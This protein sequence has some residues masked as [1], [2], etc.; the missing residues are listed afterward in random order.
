MRASASD[1]VSNEH[2]SSASSTDHKSTIPNSGT[3]QH[4]ESQTCLNRFVTPSQISSAIAASER[5]R[6]FCSITFA[7]LV[8]LSYMGFPLLGSNIINSIISF[9]PLYLVL[10]TNLTLVVARL[11][12]NNRRGF[13]R[14]VAGEFSVPSTGKYDWAEQAGK[15]LEVGLLMQKAIEAIFMDF[16]VYAVIVIAFF[17]FVQ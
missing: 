11:L 17:S 3:V 5:S 14:V 9:R 10:L 4:L 12:F 2:S 8:V 15:A 7:L 6:V 13:G 1:G 16:S